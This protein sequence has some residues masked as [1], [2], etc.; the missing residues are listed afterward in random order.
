[1]PLPLPS[2]DDRTWKD[3]TDQGTA[4]IPRYSANWTVR[5]VSDPGVTV[6]EM[7]A[8]LTEMTVYRLNRVPDRHRE[9]FLHLLGFSR[10]NPEPARAFLSFAPDT[11]TSPFELPAGVEFQGTTPDGLR[12]PFETVRDLEISPV[13]LNAVQWDPGDGNIQNLTS[14]WLDGVPLALFCKYPQPR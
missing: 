11:S 9:K 7:L 13:I 8:W 5:N 4:L 3:L 2:L 1:M 10:K 12:V 14:Q 6:V